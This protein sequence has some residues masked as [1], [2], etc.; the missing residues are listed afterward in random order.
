MSRI[1]WLIIPLYL[2]ADVN[3]C[4][5][6]TCQ[7]GGTCKELQNEVWPFKCECQGA[8]AGQFCEIGNEIK[9]FLEID[10]F[11]V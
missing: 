11:C 3:Y 6:V 4:D 5:I 8:Y 10:I 7:N 9:P 2:V 1:R